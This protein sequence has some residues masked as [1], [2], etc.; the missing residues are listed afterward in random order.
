VL[1]FERGVFISSLFLLP[2]IMAAQDLY[3]QWID[4]KKSK[5]KQKRKNFFIK[6]REIH[7]KKCLCNISLVLDVWFP[8]Y[9]R[10]KG[11]I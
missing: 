1:L 5:D 2:L 9:F 6:T 7:K 10:D 8:K 3:Q 11:M 4:V